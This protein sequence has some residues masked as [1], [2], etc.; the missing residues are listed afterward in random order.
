[1]ANQAKNI[2]CSVCARWDADALDSSRGGDG[3]KHRPDAAR[4]DTVSGKASSTFQ[5]LGGADKRSARQCPV[6]RTARASGR[7]FAASVLGGALLILLP[8]SGSGWVRDMQRS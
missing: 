7:S 1:M 5:A 8:N 6:R 3:T 2:K 4:S